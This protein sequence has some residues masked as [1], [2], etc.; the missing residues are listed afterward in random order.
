[1]ID[2]ILFLQI[3]KRKKLLDDT[4]IMFV[5]D[6]G[7]NMF[8]INFALKNEDF[9]KEKTLPLLFYMFPKNSLDKT[10]KDNLKY[11]KHAFVTPF[12]IG[13]TI[14]NIFNVESKYYNYNGTSLFKKLD[15]KNNCNRFI[16]VKIMDDEE[17]RC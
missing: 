13:N 16:S 8:G 6:H 4:A 17:C 12:D 11:N 15:I 3:F 5:S 14:L 10:T 2:Y 1:M 7:N 9:E